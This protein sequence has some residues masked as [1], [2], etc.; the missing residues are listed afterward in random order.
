MLLAACSLAGLSIGLAAFLVLSS[1]DQTAKCMIANQL[2]RASSLAI[3]PARIRSGLRVWGMGLLL[4]MVAG[5][6]T[7]T[8]PLAITIALIMLFVPGWYMSWA[9]ARRRELLRDQMVG[10]TQAL[11]HSARAGQSLTQGLAS[12]SGD[13]PQ[14]IAGELQRIMAEYD[15]GRP[16][17]EALLDAKKRLAID[18]FS[19]FVSAIV[20]SL[21]RGGKITLALERISH[22]LRENQR[23]ER[24]L[25]AETAGGWRVVLILAAFPFLF[26]AGFFVIHPVGTSLMFTTLLG[27]TLVIIMIGLVVVSVWWSR[28]I[29]N[30]VKT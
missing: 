13:A 26:L 23:V 30:T 7:R 15:H 21:E 25:A 1:W 24:K 22:S 9:I 19:M 12:V 20:V 10:C 14:P 28:K 5:M 2:D 16:L 11:A 3:D 8:L 27:Q 29:L 17:P 6:L 4:L 18:S